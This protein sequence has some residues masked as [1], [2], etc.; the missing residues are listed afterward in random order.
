MQLQDQTSLSKN[1]KQIEPKN[2]L[3]NLLNSAKSNNNQVSNFSSQSQVNPLSQY[4][5]N[6]KIVQ[7]KI[8]DKIFRTSSHF[9]PEKNKVFKSLEGLV[10]SSSAKKELLKKVQ[11]NFGSKK[12]KAT[13]EDLLKFFSESTDPTKNK[14]FR[15][16]EKF[17]QEK[18]GIKKDVLVKHRQELAKKQAL[19][20]RIEQ[21]KVDI[22]KETFSAIRGI[23]RR[24]GENEKVML[25]SEFSNPKDRII[26]AAKYN[27]VSSRVATGRGV[28]SVKKAP[29][30]SL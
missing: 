23:G 16:A 19:E 6:G 17:V 13:T 14:D 9:S 25:S 11:E 2:S 29:L 21:R 12:E 30:Y 1:P 27:P 26:K 5:K 3:G 20:Q 18:F 24:I 4:F 8:D 10:S 28:T 15:T 22:Q 7:Q